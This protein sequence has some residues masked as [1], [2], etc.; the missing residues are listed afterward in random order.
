MSVIK[1][2]LILSVQKIRLSL[3]IIDLFVQLILYL[4]PHVE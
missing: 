1:K 2:T 4:F 3:R